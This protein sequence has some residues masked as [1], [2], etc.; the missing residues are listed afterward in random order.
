[1]QNRILILLFTLLGVLPLLH[2]QSEKDS[3]Q[4][5]ELDI[6]D[7]IGQKKASLSDFT[8][9]SSLSASNTSIEMQR[10][11]SIADFLAQHTPYPVRQNGN[12]MM[13]TLSLRGTSASHT[14][15]I[16]NEIT[17]SP[18]TMG[19]TDYSIL[20][21]YFFDKI[22]VYPGGESAIFGGGA[23]GGA[24]TLSSGADNPTPARLTIDAGLGSFGKKSAGL[25]S[26]IG[27]KK[28]QNETALFFNQCD[29]DFPFSYRGE[30]M[31]QKNASYFNYGILNQ[32]NIRIN[33]W[34]TLGGDVW[35]TKYN[36]DIQPMMQNN[37][38]P[39][40]YEE[41]SDQS[42]KVVLHHEFDKN[43]WH[44]RNKAAWINDR[45]EYKGDLIATHD[46]SFHSNLR[47]KIYGTRFHT[48]PLIEIGGDI[49]YIRPEVY[50]YKEGTEERRG[51]IFLL[52]QIKPIKRL[53][54]R[55]NVRKEFV[56]DMTIPLSFSFGT[57]T[58]AVIGEHVQWTLGGNLAKNT[59]TPTLNDRYW[60]EMG[61]KDLE[62]ETSF[63]L[64]FKSETK[65]SFRRY[66]II[67]AATLYRNDVDNWIMW[68]P[69]GT[70][71]KPI[72]VD[73]VLAR[74]V[75][76]GIT[77]EFSIAKTTHSLRYL[78]NHSFTE[79]K[80][81]FSNMRPFIGH[82]MPLLPQNTFAGTWT[83]KFKHADVSLSGHYT[84]ERTTSDIF[85]ILEGYFLLDLAA[86]YDII[87]KSKRRRDHTLTPTVQ[88]NNL[89][90]KEYQNIPFRGMPG[91][92][93]SFNIRWSF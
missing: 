54:L 55:G 42:T 1:M 12:G 8:G 27:N 19:Q 66:N 91:R 39:S 38:D 88:I 14:Q 68:L 57:E 60:G 32:T 3:I 71:W 81:G 53:T 20:P 9:A 40:K 82:Q 80:K 36:R 17:I 86:E 51:S 18:L 79:I 22:D 65:A 4:A 29:N 74:G 33:Q 58:P 46:I 61:N 73:N 89:L 21:T 28:A 76:W 31:R 56:T 84:G 11:K 7:V 44:L 26:H 16:W 25:R 2:A 47:H 6:I 45:E 85:D 48:P 52:S 49:H 37:D 75:E 90:D 87:I 69:R 93:I 10:H 30:G 77:Q 24:V 63:N 62:S 35:F 92:N 34:N 15:V 59:K 41:I 70:I 50:A 78:F 72:N 64:E 23:I 67:I 43:A 5:T 83:T 13:T